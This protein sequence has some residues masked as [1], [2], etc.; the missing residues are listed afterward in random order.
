LSLEGYN[1]RLKELA[2]TDLTAEKYAILE[3]LKAYGRQLQHRYRL[4]VE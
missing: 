4:E 1:C 3:S 2:A